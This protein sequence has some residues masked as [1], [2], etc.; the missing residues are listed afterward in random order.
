MKLST[1]TEG[2][3]K[4]F[5]ERE[6]IRMLARAGYDAL[7]LSCFDMLQDDNEK[8]QDGYREYAR[9]LKRIAEGEGVTFN[10]AHAPFPSSMPDDAWT[11][12]AFRRIVR[13]MEIASIVGA[14]NIIVHPKQHLVYAE[15][16][17]A[18]KEMNLEFY[19]SLLPY[20]EEFNINVALENMWQT[21]EKGTIIRSTCASPEEFCEY[22]DRLDSPRM[23]ACLDIGHAQLTEK[24]VPGVIR[25]LGK[26]LK[27]LHVHSAD[28]NTDMHIM[29]FVAGYTPWDK[30]MEA[31]RE[32]GYDGELTYEADNSLARV[33]RELVP[34]TMRYMVEIGRYLTKQGE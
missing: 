9:E 4:L 14:R 16:A 24:D 21:D 23:V 12:D 1:Q 7:D 18:L 11:K 13:S 8:M 34:A 28:Y 2:A 25:A 29:P 20:C 19:R 3:A 31:L 17:E 27:A 10:Q 15:N 6:A 33:P 5:G 22:V 26:R 32:V 30:V